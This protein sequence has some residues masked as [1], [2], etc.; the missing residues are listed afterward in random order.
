[1]DEFVRLLD[2]CGNMA[3]ALPS[4]NDSVSPLE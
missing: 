3:R 2:L 4:D 1:M